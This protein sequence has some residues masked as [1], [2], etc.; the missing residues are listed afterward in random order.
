MMKLILL[1]IV[2]VLLGVALA[3][4]VLAIVVPALIRTGFLSVGDPAA[5]VLISIVLILG[6]CTL[7]LRPRGALR[8][9]RKRS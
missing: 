6:V 1:A 5:A 4:V 8:R 9:L 7:L 2:D 3:G